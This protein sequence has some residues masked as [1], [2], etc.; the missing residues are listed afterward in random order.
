[1]S[2]YETV[3]YETQANVALIT[4][5]RPE[6]RNALNM[7]LNKDLLAA[8]R[9]AAA[10]DQVR[11]IVLTGAGDGFCAGADLTIFSQ[12]PTPEQLQQVIIESYDPLMT[13]MVTM[14]KPIIAAINGVAA[15]A[16]LSLALAGDLQVMADDASLMMAFS[17]IAFVPDAGATWLVMRRLGYGRAYQLA[18]EGERISAEQCLAWGLTNKV[19]PADQLLAE[20]LAWAHKLAQRPTLALGLTKQALTFAAENDLSA[21][22]A[23][24]ARLQMQTLVSQDFAEGVMA[25]MQK[26]EPV[27]RGK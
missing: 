8:F 4:M 5:N 19:V 23:N 15:G 2:D 24:E 10:D 3:L 21:V 20:A 14:P 11:A 9:Q 13:L 7:T 26:R 27:F 16:G 12:L 17:N 18:A 25:F 22:I 6:R 1:M